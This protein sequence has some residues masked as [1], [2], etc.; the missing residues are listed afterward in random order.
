MGVHFKALILGC[1]SASALATRSSRKCK[2]VPH[3]PDWPPASVWDALNKTISGNLIAPVPP[4]AVCHP[5]QPNYDNATCGIVA[6]LWKSSWAFHADNP[7][8][9]AENNWSN[10]TCLPDAQYPCS[11]AGYPVYVVNASK[12][13]HVQAGVNFARRNNI[14]LV[15]KG[16]G[17]DYRGR[18]I[19]PYSLS[20]WT[21]NL[22]GLSYHQNYRTCGY[23]SSLD[24]NAYEGPAITVSAGENLGAA[25]ALANQHGSMILVGSAETVGVG[26]FLTG[27]GQ[28]LISLQRGIGADAVLEVSIVL[29]SGEL[30]TANACQNPDVFW[31]VR[32]GGGSTF[33]VVLGF[34]IKAFPSIPVTGLDFGFQSPTVNE[35]KFWEAMKYMATQF[36]MLCNSEVTMYASL[37]P[38]D[39]THSSVFQGTFHGL[40]QSVAQTAAIMDS[41]V[42]H[43]NTSYG[44]D[45]QSQA[46]EIQAWDSFYDWWISHPD[47]TSTEGLD[48]IFASRILDEEALNHPNFV[49]LIKQAAG[50]IGISFNGVAGPGTHAYPSDFSAATPAWRSG[51]VHSSKFNQDMAW[52]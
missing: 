28:S 10:D 14:R 32:G 24:P 9:L 31:A 23:H 19:A 49:S 20:I 37:I 47:N 7:V 1:L 2:A 34:I 45:L 26:G 25:F 52:K 35:G 8:S 29:P 21:R 17:H 33:G 15:I 43:F 44:S 5:D 12:P 42:E 38:G 3:S 40:N 18:S 50:G 4:G 11:R 30:V 46:T 27:G 16:T 13:E 48:L 6:S 41:L 51:Y 39:G 36:P 22:R